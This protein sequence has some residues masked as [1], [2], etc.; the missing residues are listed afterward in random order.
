MTPRKSKG[1]ANSKCDIRGTR[2]V[3]PT[4]VYPKST[5]S[6]NSL[7]LVNVRHEVAEIP[8]KCSLPRGGMEAPACSAPGSLFPRDR[9]FLP[10]SMLHS[11]QTALISPRCIWLFPLVEWT[12]DRFPWNKI[13]GL[14]LL[15]LD[16]RSKR[17]TI[18]G[19]VLSLVHCLLNDK[20]QMRHAILQG[21][22]RMLHGLP[23][24]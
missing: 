22:S 3:G 15:R 5:C 21:H 14:S 7:T 2:V 9:R 24:M 12:P 13:G 19:K 18:V 4:T 23:T 17:W 20:Y 10:G 6:R 1:R 8:M 16:N 11:T